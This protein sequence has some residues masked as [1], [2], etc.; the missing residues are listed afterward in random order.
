MWGKIPASYELNLKILFDTLPIVIVFIILPNVYHG[1]I[2]NA[3]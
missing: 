2:P 1:K 3:Q